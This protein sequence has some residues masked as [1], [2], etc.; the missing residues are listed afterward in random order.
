[1]SDNADTEGS[2]VQQKGKRSLIVRGASQDC[3]GVATIM[4]V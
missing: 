2:Y 1:M 4:I 3:H